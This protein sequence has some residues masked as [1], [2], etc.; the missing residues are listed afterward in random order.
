MPY[1][2]KQ[3]AEGKKFNQM[4][5]DEVYKLIYLLEEG[6]STLLE[7]IV[8]PMASLPVYAISSRDPRIDAA[9]KL[10]RSAVDRAVH[11]LARA[12]YK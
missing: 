9:D 4:V 1:L 6:N 5:E 8:G 7:P 11:P 2:Q 10:G 3:E 12:L